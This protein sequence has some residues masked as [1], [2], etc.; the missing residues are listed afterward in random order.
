[1]GTPM[2]YIVYFNRIHCTARVHESSCNRPKVHGGGS[3]RVPPTG[4]YEEGIG[5]FEHALE[6]ARRTGYTVLHCKTCRPG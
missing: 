6:V 5:S 3:T 2:T 4:W 1:M